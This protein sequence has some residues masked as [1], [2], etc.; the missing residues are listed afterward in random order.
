MLMCLPSRLLTVHPIGKRPVLEMMMRSSYTRICQ[1]HNEDCQIAT[2][3]L[4]GILIWIFLSSLKNIY[5]LQS[6][7]LN[8]RVIY[9]H[10]V[11]A[12]RRYFSY[13]NST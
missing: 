11:L 1:T 5:R 3:Q 2:I 10:N 9:I 6:N 13:L 12:K 8:E 7:E 4:P